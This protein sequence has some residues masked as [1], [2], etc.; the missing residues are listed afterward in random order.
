[1]SIIDN[2][3]SRA[4]NQLGLSKQQVDK[5]KSIIDIIDVEEYTDHI[6][7]S[8]NLKNIKIEIKK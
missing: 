2:I 1:M 7:I 8:I 5:V 6:Q 3:L 4:L